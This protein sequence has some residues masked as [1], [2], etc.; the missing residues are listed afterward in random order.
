M[1][2]LSDQKVKKD[3]KDNGE[4]HRHFILTNSAKLQNHPTTVSVAE[5]GWSAFTDFTLSRWGRP[6]PRG[7]CTFSLSAGISFIL[8]FFL[9]LLLVGG[10][11]SGGGWILLMSTMRTFLRTPDDP[12]DDPSFSFSLSSVVSPSSC[13]FASLFLRS[14]L[15]P[16]D[17]KHGKMEKSKTHAVTAPT[18]NDHP[19]SRVASL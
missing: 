9:L 3:D 14:Y 17:T 6:S 10:L 4:M 16:S 15:L 18:K 8:S 19:G 13:V 7:C 1:Y 2:L 11:T 5:G 12:F